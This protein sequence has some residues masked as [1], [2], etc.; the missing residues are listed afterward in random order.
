MSHSFSLSK[1][2][3]APHSPETFG[4]VVLSKAEWDGRN[5]ENGSGSSGKP[6]TALP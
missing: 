3:L 6:Q 1:L 2:K 5:P 4:A